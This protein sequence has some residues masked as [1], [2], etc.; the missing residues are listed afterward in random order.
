[1]RSAGKSSFCEMLAPSSKHFKGDAFDYFEY[2][3]TKRSKFQVWDLS[4]KYPHL[5]SHHTSNANGFI[6]VVD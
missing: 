3:Y 2:D 4:G 6:F 5:W 1:M